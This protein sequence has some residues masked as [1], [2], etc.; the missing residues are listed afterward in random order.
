MTMPTT[1]LTLPRNYKRSYNRFCQI[2]N[3][4]S[5]R[6][7]MIMTQ[8]LTALGFAFYDGIRPEEK[9]NDDQKTQAIK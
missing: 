6:Q 2:S 3:L 8:K 4:K 7:M 5:T 9:L 1:L